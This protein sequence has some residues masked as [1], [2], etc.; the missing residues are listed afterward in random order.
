M[1]T[2]KKR[3]NS[4]AVEKLSER[5]VLNLQ[6]SSCLIFNVFLFKNYTEDKDFKYNIGNKID[7]KNL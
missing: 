5:M 2:E 3:Q 7:H 6:L 4:T 1:I